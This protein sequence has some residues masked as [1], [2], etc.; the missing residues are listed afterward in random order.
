M[1]SYNTYLICNCVRTRPSLKRNV[2]TYACTPSLVPFIFRD[3]IFRVYSLCVC[4]CVC[5]CVYARVCA[6][7]RSIPRVFP[8]SVC[9][10]RCVRVS[11]ISTC[12]Y[13]C[14]CIFPCIYFS[15]CV[16][17][18]NESTYASVCVCVCLHIYVY[19]T[20]VSHS[21]PASLHSGHPAFVFAC[22]FF[23]MNR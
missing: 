1:H 21:V 19:T 7:G 5:T 3:G 16:Y 9:L 13:V 8:V 10:S 6:R 20:R 17:V 15:A 4:M 23:R 18:S 22:A 14:T 2:I 11:N 12:E